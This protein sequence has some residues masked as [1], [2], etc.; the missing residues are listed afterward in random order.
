MLGAL[1]VILSIGIIAGCQSA[2]LKA[3][4]IAQSNLE[5]DRLT[6]NQ[7]I[8]KALVLDA[9]QHHLP[10][11]VDGPM[12]VHA[13][14][15]FDYFLR[16]GG[17]GVVQVGVSTQ[18]PIVGVSHLHFLAV[19]PHRDDAGEAVVK[20]NDLASAV[21][22]LQQRL[23]AG[24]TVTFDAS[25][26]PSTIKLPFAALKAEMKGD[27][28]EAILKEYLFVPLANGKHHFVLLIGDHGKLTAAQQQNVVDMAEILVSRGAGVSVLA[29]GEKPDVAFLAKLS[30]TGDGVYELFNQEFSLPRWL[31]EVVANMHAARFTDISLVMNFAPRLTLGT[32]WIS[33]KY[34][35][36]ERQITVTL[37]ELKQGREKVY[38]VE[39]NVPPESDSGAGAL[40]NVV[41]RYRDKAADKILSAQTSKALMYTLDANLALTKPDKSVQ[42]S[43]TILKTADVID[44]V[45]NT[46]RDKRPYKGIAMLSKQAQEL[47]M[48]AAPRK[49]DELLRDA[50]ILDAYAQRLVSFTDESFQSLKIFRDLS[51][52]T[53]RYRDALK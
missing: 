3:T 4:S 35:V 8:N 2:P 11:P 49:D 40:V 53:A 19:L 44:E 30:G 5:Q 51:W 38:L 22:S 45:A 43:L 15:Q 31:D 12:A 41:A 33:D 39:V 50:R 17:A 10:V 25:A 28:L 13:M 23:P 32:K 21:T 34:S 1:A 6:P 16:E 48:L 9:Y 26:L 42:R 14:S 24:S 27:N 20:I 7:S 29:M 37:P 52:D 46:L 47:R 36:R 18:A